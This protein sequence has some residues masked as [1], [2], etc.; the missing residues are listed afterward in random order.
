MSQAEDPERSRPG[1]EVTLE[2]VRALMGASTPHFAM[3][4]RTRLR[5][6][7]EPLPAGHPA[8]V[9]GER[10]L[11]RLDAIAHDGEVR[12]HAPEP[13]L[14]PLASVAAGT[15]APAGADR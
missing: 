2:D 7:I 15:L 6:L 3:Q 5:A 11:A 12:G 9:M 4:L 1:Y 10:E 14:M 8:R 13:G